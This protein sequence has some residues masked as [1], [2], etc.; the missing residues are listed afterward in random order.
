MTRIAVLGG[1]VMGEAL[2]TGLLQLDPRPSI[3]VVEKSPERAQ[4]LIAK[5]G[6]TVDDGRAAVA[7]AD[8]IFAAVKPNDMRAVLGQIA[9]AVP[10]GATLISIA[11]GITTRVISGI[12]PQA[13]VVRAM[14][15]TPARI[16][17]GVVAVSAGE[18]C[19]PERF[20]AAAELLKAVGTVIEIPESL[21][22]AITATSGSGP[23]YVFYLAE[24][25]MRGAQELGLSAAEARTAVIETI[26]GSARLM[27]ESTEHPQA[28]RA[29]VTSAKG[30]TAA[31][32]AVFDERAVADSI[33]VAMT[34]A[35]DRSQELSQS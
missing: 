32:V 29:Q 6:V 26:A 8:V 30:T 3:V 15:N 14:P 31:A 9:D 28:L 2:I 23:A 35:R 24:A 4:A 11:A 10:A 20:E 5:H 7:D 16:Q 13:A 12:V 1:G 19:S 25:M 34:A 27:Q 17:R 33:V 22:D 21:Q 18:S